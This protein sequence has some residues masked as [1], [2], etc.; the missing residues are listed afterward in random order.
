MT[1]LKMRNGSFLESYIFICYHNGSK[2]KLTIWGMTMGRVNFNQEWYGI[3]AK[4]LA[5]SDDCVVVDYGC[6]GRGIVKNYNLFEGIQLCFL[7][8][9]TD[10]SMKTQKFNPDIIQI[11]HCQTG[12]YECEF[13]NHTVS[14]LPE[15]YFSV[16]ATEHLPISFSFPL[17]KYYGVSLVIDRQALSEATRQ[18]MQMIPIDLDRIGTTLGLETRWYVSHTPPQLRHL[19][20]ELYAADG[21]DPIGYF[22]IKAIELLYHMDQLTQV[23][24]CDLKYFDKKQIQ[25][26]KAIREYLVSHLDEKVSV[27]QLAKESHLNMSVFHLVFSHIYGDTPY[28]H[29]K[30]YKMNSAAQWLSENKMKIGDIALELGYSNASKFA[31]AFQSVYGML[32]KDY[33]KNR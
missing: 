13:A 25:A 2:F 33:R 20:S 23:N 18:L 9:E 15:D 32:P 6:N 28:A 10:G 8:F 24:G 16:A 30:K 29:L 22:K 31:R 17:R 5:Q 7:D 26:T 12:R 1:L 19:F 11:T 21:R 3:Q 27:E 4:V 14:Y